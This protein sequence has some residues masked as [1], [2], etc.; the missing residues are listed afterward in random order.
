MWRLQQVNAERVAKEYPTINTDDLPS[1]PPC[2]MPPDDG[3][4]D[5]S[6]VDDDS[7]RA[8]LH[9]LREAFWRAT[10]GT[11]CWEVPL[12]RD[13][14]AMPWLHKRSAGVLEA[15][16][17][18]R[19]QHGR[20]ALLVDNSADKVVDTFFLYRPVQVL[21]AKRMIM[22]ERMGRCN[23]AQLLEQ[24][25]LKLVNAMRYGQVLYVRMSTTACAFKTTYNGPTTLP[26]ALFDQAA[27][28]V[29]RTR[30][31][32][33]AAWSS[34]PLQMRRICRPTLTSVTASSRKNR[35][36]TGNE[37]VPAYASVPSATS[38]TQ[39]INT[40]RSMRFNAVET[41]GRCRSCSQSDTP[42]SSAQIASCAHGLLPSVAAMIS[43]SS[44]RTK[45]SASQYG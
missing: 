30:H 38:A 40:S 14:D 37:G 33:A 39:A 15:I 21:E 11:E 19:R 23:R 18:A 42:K 27:I 29:L 43:S 20:T 13:L 16:E 2:C 10:E 22:E 41:N 44:L 17:R 45:M 12:G 26:L 7:D 24:A 32:G 6:A 4:D 25:R 1:L 31:S 36:A 5:D 8:Q 9:A 34:F 35:I 28:D 3:D